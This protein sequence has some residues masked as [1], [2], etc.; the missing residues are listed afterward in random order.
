MKLVRKAF[1]RDF[2]LKNDECTEKTTREE[3][4][5]VYV[6]VWVVPTP[7]HIPLISQLI[8]FQW[9]RKSKYEI[10]QPRS[11]ILSSVLAVLSGSKEACIVL[12]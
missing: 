5:G 6:G 2:K 7:P 3:Q 1:L 9:I 10:D 8:F 4:G 11:A 12:S